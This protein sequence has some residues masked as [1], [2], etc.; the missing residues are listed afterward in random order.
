MVSMWC[1]WCVCGAHGEY[2]VHMVSMWCTWCVC[3]AHGVYVVHMV[4]MHASIMY[5]LLHSSQKFT[6]VQTFQEATATFTID[7]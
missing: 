7:Q 4:C 5:H 2:V 3:G 6:L 1:T